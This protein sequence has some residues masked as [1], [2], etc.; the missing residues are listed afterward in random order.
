MSFTK[1]SDVDLNSRG[2]TTLPNQ[3]TISAQELKE[4]FDAPAKEIV[5][6]KF[7]NL[8][9]E[10]EAST[11]AASLGAEAPTGFTGA[12]IQAL[13]NAIAS[14]VKTI[15]AIQV[16]A[17]PPPGTTGDNVQTIINE[18]NTSIT[19][20]QADITDLN[21]K[22]HTHANK[23]VID[24]FSEVGG[25]PYY[26]GNPIGGGGSITVDS[27]LSTTSTNPVQN[28]VIT[29]TLNSMGT[30]S[31]IADAVAKTHT[32]SNKALLDT[33]TQT[34]SDI[35]DAVTKK[36]THSNKSVLDKIA[37]D[38]SGNPTYNGSTIP[39]SSGGYQ[40]FIDS[41]I[42]PPSGGGATGDLVLVGNTSNKDL[43]RYENGSWGKI[44]LS[45]SNPIEYS[46]NDLTPGVT[47]L[48]TGTVF[49]VYE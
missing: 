43:Y 7:N 23:A 45:S 22:K 46:D 4:E 1:I 8:I 11:A 29:N 49:L 6:P 41:D 28:K 18:I 40:K 31:D 27:E 38:G 19:N 12:N 33:Y 32:H 5:A 44:T 2:A 14:A 35:A 9:D 48:A 30:P 26:D 25:D 42:V 47:P 13:L 10:L 37:E 15:E 36:H 20:I 17:T 24:K 34:D 21:A 39:T 16:G 3:P